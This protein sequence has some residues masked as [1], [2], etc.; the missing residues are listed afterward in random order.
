[1]F[2][3]DLVCCEDWEFQ[4]RLYHS[5]RV[6]VLPQVWSHVRRFND[7]SRSGRGVP[8]RPTTPEQE[9]MLLRSR[10]TVMERAD[11]LQGLE[12]NLASEL[13]RFQAKTATDFSRIN[14]G[15]MIEEVH[16]WR[17]TPEQRALRSELVKATQFAYFDVQLDHPDW[18]DKRVLDFGGNKGNLLL[19]P[20]CTI[21]HENYYC[22]DVIREA[23]DEGRKTFPQAHWFHY[24]RYNPSF[25]PDG[26]IVL[27]VPDMG[28]EFDVIL[29]YSVFTHTAWEETKD[30][31]EQL[32]A[33]LALGGVLAFTFI[34]PRGSR[35]C[36]GDLKSETLPLRLRL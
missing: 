5:C 4:M 1:L 32:R 34:D 14:T 19:D 6:V 16:L 21:R 3:E 33:R 11:W 7:A 17:G 22:L 10:L 12:A 13:E 36:V 20:A 18:R 8:G 15:F 23:I 2:A 30:L 29:A 9:L 27:P 31:I 28:V 35:I 24:D 26:T 25:N